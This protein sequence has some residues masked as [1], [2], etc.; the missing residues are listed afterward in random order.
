MRLLS[1]TA[2]ATLAISLVS[3]TLH[4]HQPAAPQAAA[5]PIAAR[6]VKRKELEAKEK[7]PEF[8]DKRHLNP[9]QGP[10]GGCPFAGIG[11]NDHSR[12]KR[13]E[14]IHEVRYDDEVNIL[15]PREIADFLVSRGRYTATNGTSLIDRSFLN[16]LEKGEAM[17]AKR[18]R[19]SRA[20]SD[21]VSDTL[22]SIGMPVYR[23]WKERTLNGLDATFHLSETTAFNVRDIPLIE[24]ALL[25]NPEFKETQILGYRITRRFI[26]AANALN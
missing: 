6:Q 20:L 1:L 26:E 9:S 10:G 3:A 11:G 24:R 23:Q 7:Y 2:F 16:G 25:E 21:A 18:S 13:S 15:K 22:V 5:D 4:Q 8:F 14:V 19:W 12:G 17:L